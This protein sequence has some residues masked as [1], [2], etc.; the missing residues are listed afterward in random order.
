[1]ALFRRNTRTIGKEEPPNI[2]PP[3]QSQSPQS[4]NLLESSPEAS[5]EDQESEKEENLEEENT[6]EKDS[7][8]EETKEQEE[9]ETQGQNIESN[10]CYKLW[11]E[12]LNGSDSS[13]SNDENKQN[14][15]HQE[16]PA[17]EDEPEEEEPTSILRLATMAA[18]ARVNQSKQESD[19]FTEK[20]KSGLKDLEA[21]KQQLEKSLGDKVHEAKDRMIEQATEQHE[22]FMTTSSNNMLQHNKNVQNLVS[23]KL[24]ELHMSL[25]H[26]W[27]C[28][29]PPPHRSRRTP[30]T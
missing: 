25:I 30:A 5:Q 23:N 29:R 17:T 11:T 9:T 22:K 26:I 6:R 24:Q 12:E 15:P 21:R 16:S 20:I 14:T 18:K 8:A 4:P 2:A 3:E 1:M 27:R 19:I 7:G 13:S 28:R 10:Q